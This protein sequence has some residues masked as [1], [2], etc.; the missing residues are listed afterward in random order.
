MK[1]TVYIPSAMAREIIPQMEVCRTIC[2][3]PRGEGPPR[4][5]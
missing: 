4:A 2:R 5:E 3:T 1:P